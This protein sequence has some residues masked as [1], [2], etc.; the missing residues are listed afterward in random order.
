[1]RVVALLSQAGLL[2]RKRRSEFIAAVWLSWNSM[3][4]RGWM[5]GSCGGG[6][7]ERGSCCG[8]APRQARACGV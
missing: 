6:G 8:A 4:R 3:G 1:M 7:E 5:A 2:K